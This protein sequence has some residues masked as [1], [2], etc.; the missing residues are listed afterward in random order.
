MRKQLVVAALVIVVLVAGI[1]TGT[2]LVAQALA[3]TLSGN[4]GAPIATD[5][6]E[7]ASTPGG[8]A[9]SSPSPYQPTTPSFIAHK[10]V[11]GEPL[12]TDAQ[13]N[14]YYLAQSS[15]ITG[16]LANTMLAIHEGQIEV[17]CMADR[18]W[19]YDPRYRSGLAS[20]SPEDLALNGK[21]GAGD[22][23]R[24]QD[25]GCYGLAVHQTGATS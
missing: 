15:T 12:I 21:T 14:D 11:P 17:R 23:Y 25:A 9:S 8:T 2:A 24:W 5:R 4:D 22:A 13:I 7:A 6:S 18:G 19:W 16:D 1:T 20:G 10:L 3:N